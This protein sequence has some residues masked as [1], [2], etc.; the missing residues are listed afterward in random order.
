MRSIEDLS[1][2]TFVKP[3]GR[4][5][6]ETLGDHQVVPRYNFPMTLDT[7]CGRVWAERRAF[8]FDRLRR[9]LLFLSEQPE[10]PSAAGPPVPV[11]T[12]GDV[13]FVLDVG[14]GR[15]VLVPLLLPPPEEV[16]SLAM[17]PPGKTYATLGSKIWKSL[18][19]Q[20][21]DLWE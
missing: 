15:L 21:M 10:E 7:R 12:A 9:L 8:Q 17:G 6:N 5:R 19:R 3:V 2:L 18:T 20:T 13:T 16:T 14:L 11:G 1:D 4:K